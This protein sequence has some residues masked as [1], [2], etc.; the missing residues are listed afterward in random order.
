[1]PVKEVSFNKVTGLHPAI[2]QKKWTP[3]QVFFKALFFQLYS[4]AYFQ[5]QLWMA[6]SE[7]L[8]KG[9]SKHPVISFITYFL[10]LKPW[11]EINKNKI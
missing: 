5:E 3:S 6:A 10:K 4:N 2:L 9:I 8:L 11:N 1:M 7:F